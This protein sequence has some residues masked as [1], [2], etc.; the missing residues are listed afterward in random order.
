MGVM[1]R[2]S[3]RGLLCGKECTPD[4]VNDDQP[5]LEGD[6]GGSAWVEANNMLRS[7]NSLNNL[8][9]QSFHIKTHPSFNL[10]WTDE[11]CE[12]A[13]LFVLIFFTFTTQSWEKTMDATAN[14][15]LL[16]VN[17]LTTGASLGGKTERTDSSHNNIKAILKLCY[18]CLMQYIFVWAYSGWF[19]ILSQSWLKKIIVTT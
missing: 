7:S 15:V 6:G 16:S 11:V 8:S 14:S 3:C 4:D 18:N 9:H 12:C 13:K 5:Q 10:Y 19:Q 1:F 17:S 2:R